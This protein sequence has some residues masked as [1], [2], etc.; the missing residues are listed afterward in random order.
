MADRYPFL[1]EENIM[2]K[3]LL[4]GAGL[5]TR[6]L[7]NYL[8]DKGYYLIN[9]SRTLSKAQALVGDHPNARAIQLNVQDSEALEQL[10]KDADVVI[11]LLPYTHHVKVAKLCIAHKVHFVSTSYVSAEM[12]AL[13]ADAKAAGIV[14]LNELGVDPGID[15]MSA[16]KIIDWVHGQGGKIMSF[17]S[18]CGGL[19]A[20]EANDNPFGYKFSWSPIGVLMAGTN[21]ARYKEDGRI[22]EIPG[23][24]LFSHYKILHVEGLGRLEG[25]PNRDSVPYIDT[26]GMQETQ[27]CFRGTYRNL[28]WCDT[29]KAM[30]DLGILDKTEKDFTGKTLAGIMTDYVGGD[31]SGVRDAA[32]AKLGMKPDDPVLDR[33]DWLGLFSDTPT[34]VEKGSMLEVLAEVM[35][36][37]MPYKDGERDMIVLTHDF[38][39]E[40]PG[41]NKHIT[42]TLIDYGIPHGDTS[43][44]RT[45][46]LPAAIGTHMILQ[47]KITR[48]G[49]C[50]PV[51]ADIYEPILAELET[52]DIRCVEKYEDL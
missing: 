31:A 18:Y 8:L 29:V 1:S 5:V 22:V 37:K 19:P 20:P 15:H 46:S 25:Y 30:A 48:P 26:Y 36:A 23:K 13:D 52:L 40:L 45:V 41:G 51:A 11:S 32:A 50:I 43:M 39:A 4:L 44:A 9:A 33:L 28:G 16:K 10:V 2:Q 49:V 34:K 47:G 3:I 12:A 17:R 6:P 14:V 38:I 42:S 7:V 27:T 24:D 35:M 21:N